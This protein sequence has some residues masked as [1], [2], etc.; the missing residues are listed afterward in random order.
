MPFLNSLTQGVGG[1]IGTTTQVTQFLLSTSSPT[2]DSP[3]RLCHIH[4]FT[5]LAL[6]TAFMDT[7]FFLPIFLVLFWTLASP[8]PLK[9]ILNS[10]PLKIIRDILQT[11]K[12]MRSSE[13]MSELTDFGLPTVFLREKR[14]LVA[15]KK[16]VVLN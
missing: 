11:F 7:T 13:K 3:N 9:L 16:A 1:R 15:Q 14:H 10:F 2:P 6:L 4:G 12:F 5:A 8:A